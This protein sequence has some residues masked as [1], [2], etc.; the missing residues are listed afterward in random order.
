MNT[1]LLEFI[2]DEN[3]IKHNQ[4]GFMP[5]HRTSDH[6]LVLKTLIDCFKNAKKS[7]YLCFVDL[8]KAFDT[9]YHEGLIYKLKQLHFSTKFINIIKS[10]YSK[11]TAR[12]KTLNGLTE[13]F[14]ISIGTRQGCN[15]SPL[16]FNLYIND[17]PGQLMCKE[18][19]VV[20]VG[21]TELKCLMYA[22]DIVLLNKTEH[23]MNLYLNQLEQYCNKW[24]LRIS[25]QKTKILIINTHSKIH[26]I[27]SKT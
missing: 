7:L 15:L 22:D 8:K 26:A 16:L 6:I 5:K 2:D 4:I 12:V 20:K 14:P 24:R 11:V 18:R 17:L 13:E 25:V 3:M 10:M 27:Q 21:N 9:V 1:R 23:G 19:D